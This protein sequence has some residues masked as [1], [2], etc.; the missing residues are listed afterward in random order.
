ML[1]R[2]VSSIQPNKNGDRMEA[3]HRHA[4]HSPTGGY[5][6]SILRKSL[7]DRVGSSLACLHQ[8]TIGVAVIFIRPHSLVVG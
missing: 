6:D 2:A 1:Y 7:E 3:K 5:G 4:C 8:G